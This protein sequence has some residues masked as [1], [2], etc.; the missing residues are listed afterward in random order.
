MK[1]KLIVFTF[2]YLVLFICNV[3]AYN[4]PDRVV[5]TVSGNNAN[6]GTIFAPWKTMTWAVANLASG[7][8]L[9]VKEGTYTED[10][11]IDGL[12]G[13]ASN[14]T[15]IRAWPGH[16]VTLKSTG[17]TGSGR[18]KINNCD[19]LKL[20]GFNITYFNQGIFVEGGSTYIE[21]RDNTVYDVGQEA[22][23]VKG[24]SSYVTI[25]NNII[26]GTDKAGYNGEGIYIGDPDANDRTH[27]ITIS[28]NWIY[29]TTDDEAIDI[30]DAAHHVTID[31]NLIY[32]AGSAYAYDEA[33]LI[34]MD[35]D[36]GYN[37]N[38]EHIV[39]NNII[40]DCGHASGAAIYADT[41]CS[42][43]NNIIYD[44]AYG[45]SLRN[46]SGDSWTRYVYHNTMQTI[47][48]GLSISGTQT[49]NIRNNIGT[50]DTGECA[51]CN[52]A[53][54]AA[55]FVNTTEGTENFHLVA[56]S[57]PINAGVDLSS[58][59][60]TDID[61]DARGTDIGADDYTS[62][63]KWATTASRA[64]VVTAINSASN[65]DYIH[66]PAGSVSWASKITMPNTKVFKIKGAGMAR[67][68]IAVPSGAFLWDMPSTS[69]VLEISDITFNLSGYGG[70]GAIM[71]GDNNPHSGGLNGF[72][73]HHCS[74][75][76]S[77]SCA[78]YITQNIEDGYLLSGVID[79]C[80]FR[81]ISGSSN[82]QVQFYGAGPSSNSI[83]GAYLFPYETTENNKSVY[84]EDCSFKNNVISD[85]AL[86]TYG[87]ARYVFR[88]NAVTNTNVE[89]HGADSGGYRGTM[90]WAIYNNTFANTSASGRA[91]H[92]RS[93]TGVIFGNTYV[94]NYGRIDLAI[95]RTDES[96]APWGLCNGNST[97]DE[98]QPGLSGY[99]CLDQPGHVFGPTSGGVNDL[100]PIYG[101]NNNKNQTSL[102]ITLTEE[103]A[104]QA[105]Y[106][107]A[108]REYYQ[109]G[110]VAQTSSSFPFNGSTG[111]G[112]GILVNR[113]MSGL[114][115]GVGYWDTDNSILYRAISSNSWEQLYTPYTY[116][117]PLRGE[118]GVTDITPPVLSG[119]LPSGAQ[120][121]AESSWPYTALNLACNTDESATCKYDV[122][123]V[124]YDSMTG[125]FTTTGATTH[126]A[127]G[128]FSC[129]S[130]FVY[131]YRCMDTAGNKNTT[132]SIASFT[133]DK[134]PPPRKV[135]NISNLRL[136]K[137]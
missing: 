21:I 136:R 115:V 10:W 11:T 15:V 89:H 137:N 9:W 17:Y 46:T 37:A 43:Y 85:G 88:Y 50:T 132:S 116:P 18:I 51:S 75:T 57:A 127:S 68:T 119:I 109:G 19:Y 73:I 106:M 124:A 70:D 53:Y 42:I 3:H 104:R 32:G 91:G 1:K 64:D 69:Y 48:S 131:Y 108:D 101:W 121:C 103:H 81:D 76:N 33:G 40:H 107:H 126:S 63:R 78:I 6:A 28:N 86:D 44:C 4:T 84:V 38:P 27:H 12:T 47:T 59:V 31:G 56:G 24:N 20:I 74:F 135:Y 66:I 128:T 77:T 36:G 94:G 49:H 122:S 99:A 55:Y 80:T 30:K 58:T 87:G 71:L 93:G 79:N 105:D 60:T 52:I 133:I 2:L 54:N 16:T 129:G 102:P 14:Y 97:W 25:D 45:I 134:D 83:H 13:S 8:E 65:G 39:K 41:G 113:P 123:D 35:D 114:T 82:K 98:N 23:H 34:N 61:G 95:Y 117:H 100:K 120:Q 90:K 110:I 92:Y 112:F 62:N 72:R 111:M 22:I 5:D 26:Y 67:T 125:T 96:M 7:E 130:A 118:G 29:T